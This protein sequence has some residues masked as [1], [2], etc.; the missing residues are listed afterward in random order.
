MLYVFI[1]YYT[2]SLEYFKIFNNLFTGSPGLSGSP[3]S[4]GLPGSDSLSN[5]SN[6]F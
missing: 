1:K 6:W 5:N 3:G 4:P 2:N